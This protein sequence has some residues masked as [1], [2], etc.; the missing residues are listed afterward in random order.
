M[1][2]C[3]VPGCMHVT[4]GEGWL[5]YMEPAAIVHP[6]DNPAGATSSRPLKMTHLCHS[7]CS[8]QLLCTQ[9]RLS[10]PLFSSCSS[11]IVQKQFLHSA[12]RLLSLWLSLFLWHTRTHF[13]T[14]TVGQ[15]IHPSY[16]QI[17]PELN[18]AGLEMPS[19]RSKSRMLTDTLSP[20]HV[21]NMSL[22]PTNTFNSHFVS[23]FL[24]FS[25]KCLPSWI[26]R[27]S[28]STFIK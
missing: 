9:S 17:S 6:S 26:R 14:F 20:P 27:I 5:L 3:S 2:S 21:R 10:L 12:R 23:L 18:E 24:L 15:Q 22:H 11:L 28:A 8:S 25:R 13:L 16:Q 1:G 4:R 7:V 19:Q